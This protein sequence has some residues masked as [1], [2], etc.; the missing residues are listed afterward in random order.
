MSRFVR[1]FAINIDKGTVFLCVISVLISVIIHSG[2]GDR[3]C[4]E[5]N[6]GQAA[7]L[8]PSCILSIMLRVLY[9]SPHSLVIT[10][11]GR[12][13]YCLCVSI[14]TDTSRLRKQT[15]FPGHSANK[16]WYRSLNS[17][18]SGV[19]AHILSIIHL[20]IFTSLGSFEVNTGE[21]FL[22]M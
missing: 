7:S 12:S 22:N 9:S 19:R 13:Y 18:L 16:W 8:Q 17:R 10:T 6:R 1:V 11:P 5:M 15:T 2:E 14:S 3:E 20:S 21:Y 4:R